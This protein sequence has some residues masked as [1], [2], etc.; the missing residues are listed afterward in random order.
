VTPHRHEAPAT[1]N[2]RRLLAFCLIVVLVFVDL[3][4]LGTTRPKPGVP[5]LPASSRAGGKRPAAADAR[6]S[7]LF[8]TLDAEG[9]GSALILLEREAATDSVVLREGHQLAHALGRRAAVAHG[10]DASVI[11]ECRPSFGSGCYHGV[12]EASVRAGGGI[13]MSALKKVCLAAG[14]DDRPGPRYECAHGLGHGTLGALGYDVGATLRQCDALGAGLDDWCHIGVFMEAITTALRTAMPMQHTHASAGINHFT[15]DPA[16]PYS[17]CDRVEDLYASACWLFQGFVIL[18]SDGFDA[19]AALQT[20]DGAP[21]H[22]VERCYQSIGHQLT[23]LFQHDDRWIVDRCALG[24]A[25]RAQH[26]AAGAA[27]ALTYMDWTGARAAHFCAN[28]PSG[29]KEA[30]Y[31]AAADLLSGLVS[32]ARRIAFCAGV[33]APFL[34]ACRQAAGLEGKG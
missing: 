7:L 8:S 9:L 5:V 18:R 10:G 4:L 21:A 34:G 13:D 2:R 30:C 27:L 29:W 22:R 12:V 20:C 3:A 28:G 24:R 15:I 19:A 26:C 32:P 25:D 6:T 31:R 33:E 11:R 16:D 17:P 1:F 14:S 23:G